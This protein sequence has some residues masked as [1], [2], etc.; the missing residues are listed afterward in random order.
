MLNALGQLAQINHSLICKWKEKLSLTNL[1][2]TPTQDTHTIK[3]INGGLPWHVELIAAQG[4]SFSSPLTN[5]TK[6]ERGDKRHPTQKGIFKWASQKKKSLLRNFQFTWGSIQTH[7]QSEQDDTGWRT[8]FLGV[9]G[10]F[11]LSSLEACTFG[12]YDS[13]GLMG[14]HG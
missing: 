5:C 4:K 12:W 3:R 10:I 13:W 11:F 1:T 6:L 9:L 14:L 2:Q 7:L 8:F